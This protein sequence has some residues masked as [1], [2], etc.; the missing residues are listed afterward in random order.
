MLEL[1]VPAVACVGFLWAARRASK[2]LSA[3]VLPACFTVW[4]AQVLLVGYVLSAA[5]QLANPWWWLLGCMVTAAVIGWRFR[6]GDVVVQERYAALAAR[7]PETV[8]LGAAFVLIAL[9]QLAV[10]VAAA[11]HNTDSMTYHMSRVGYY[12]QHGNIN[13]FES[14][15][16]AQL[17]H[18]KNSA[19]SMT[20]ITLV[21][22]GW[23]NA[24]QLLQY[25]SWFVL[26]L[27]HFGISVRL[28]A[29]H[30]AALIAS[31]AGSLIVEVIMQATTTQDD[32]FI[33]ALAASFL[34]FGIGA[35][36]QGSRREALLAAVAAG[37]A[38]G[39]KISAI[40]LLMA[41]AVLLVAV[42]FHLRGSMGIFPW[43]KRVIVIGALG[44]IGCLAFGLPAGYWENAR[45]YAS[46]L[47]DPAV[48]SSKSLGDHGQISQAELGLINA[49]RFGLDFIDASGVPQS[50]ASSAAVDAIRS[51]YIGAVQS[52]GID[53][54]HAPTLAPPYDIARV[55]FAAHEDF[56]YWGPW[57]LLWF[58]PLGACALFT[59]RSWRMALLLV[60]A[61]AVFVAFQSFAGIYDPWRGRY[62]I[63][64][65]VFAAPLAALGWDGIHS[66]RW[67]R[68]LLIVS[69][70]LCCLA[71]VNA[72]LD[73]HNSPWWKTLHMTWV[74]QVTRNTGEFERAFN[75]IE[76][77]VPQD[78]SIIVSLDQAYS[79]FPLFGPRLTRRLYPAPTMARM[80]ELITAGVGDY[81]IFNQLLV[82][83]EHD[84]A[85]GAGVYLRPLKGLRPASCVAAVSPRL[86]DIEVIDD[87]LRRYRLDHGSYP[88]SDG[89]DGFMSRWG[90]A[91]SD[92]IDA[93]TPGY[94]PELPVARRLSA[95]DWA[96]YLYR[97]D[98]TDY[99][100]VV[101]AASDAADVI[102]LSPQLRDPAS[103]AGAYGVWSE[104]ARN[105]RVE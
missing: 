98:G 46:P 20:F 50:Q 78:A 83:S 41:A 1:I 73:R 90:N 35:I 23:T 27:C 65:V 29:S 69:A 66:R 91:G 101:V 9:M 22:Q 71:S 15:F 76:A 105:W 45:V 19:L 33:T 93:L 18:A 13:A 38:I 24:A 86:K 55:P 40:P 4:L 104:G 5:D 54:A 84:C 96:M 21:A 51:V 11:P 26:G 80:R 88:V 32:L 92:W 30:K 8:L 103:D 64:L 82:P 99:K 52:A 77:E 75:E 42:T 48:L 34:Y 49:A 25:V 47:G 57:G 89:W 28:G 17:M 16:W 10:I 61:G 67:A 81:I 85:L 6:R 56:S 12:L 58:L 31:L 60:A 68:A 74:Q 14:N 63:Q 97:S 43:A 102:S 53:L 39:T 44:L 36:G 72:V 100:L 87:A 37:V 2:G 79:E 7:C 95:D 70:T 59:R 62:F 3:G 94:L